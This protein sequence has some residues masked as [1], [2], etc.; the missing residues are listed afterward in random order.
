MDDNPVITYKAAPPV[1][2]FATDSWLRPVVCASGTKALAGGVARFTDIDLLM[3]HDGRYVAVRMDCDDLIASA[4]DRNR[5]VTALDRLMAPRPAFAG[6]DMDRPH[7]MGVVNVTPD[8]F[9]DGGQRLAPAEAI[10]AATA[11]QT[12]GAAIIDIGGESTRPG[13]AP[14]TRNQELA[15]V[16]PPITALARAG[17]T[18]SIDTRHADVMRR[19]VA[20]GASIIN[21]IAALQGDG[22]LAAAAAS[23][24]PV[25]LMH[26]Q[27]DPQTMQDNPAYEFAPVEIYRFL[28]AR[29]AAAR[30]AGIPDAMIAL[31]PGFGFGKTVPHNLQLVNWLGLLHGLGVPIL[32]GAS[33]KSTIAALSANEPADRRLPGSLALALAACRQGAQLIRVHDVAETAQAL[34]IEVALL[35]AD[36]PAGR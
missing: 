28:E 36:R 18:I 8:S 13:A 3:R 11:M 9:S 14:V 25:I 33:R 16:L 29:I 10:A 21:D 12:A 5:A 17:A 4:D 22:A 32:F 7:L 2:P 30:A 23:G 6:L 1:P 26:M 34:A 31:D 35:A 15:R 27:G 19:A 24:V 20:G